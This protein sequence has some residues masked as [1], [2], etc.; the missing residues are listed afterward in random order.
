MAKDSD[1]LRTLKKIYPDLLGIIVCALVFWLANTGQSIGVWVN[2]F[3]PCEQ[4]PMNSFP[5]FGIY[6]ILA[7]GFAA[8]VGILFAAI[9]IYKTIKILRK[10]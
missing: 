2:H 6:D 10:K 4:Y 5:C 3:F 9:S 1:F 7:M 8:I